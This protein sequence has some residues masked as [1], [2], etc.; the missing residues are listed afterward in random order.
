MSYK[1]SNPLSPDELRRAISRNTDLHMVD[2]RTP[3][4]FQGGHIHGS[5]NVPLNELGTHADVLAALG[6]PIVLVCRSGVRAHSAER[7]LRQAGA[8]S[9][10]VLDGGVLAWSDSGQALREPAASSGGFLHRTATLL[11]LGPQHDSTAAVE[12]LVAAD[13]RGP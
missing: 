6:A 11:G 8:R 13:Q 5:Q 2:V 10:H 4:E 7:L 1:L 3:G 12:A 9:I